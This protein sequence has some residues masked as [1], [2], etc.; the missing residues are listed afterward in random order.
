MAFRHLQFIS[1]LMH[2]RWSD[3]YDRSVSSVV[4]RVTGHRHVRVKRSSALKK[5]ASLLHQPAISGLSRT[6]AHSL[7]P[8]HRIRPTSM[9][10][11][12]RRGIARFSGVFQM[13]RADSFASF[14][15]KVTT[16]TFRKC[17]S[18]KFKTYEI[19]RLRYV[20]FE[21]I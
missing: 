14:H 16:Y 11:G 21:E 4:S 5:C 2:A 18:F 9:T 12:R 6:S 7:L 15:T 13:T 1:R 17:T 10:T 8:K 3:C 20:I 19:A